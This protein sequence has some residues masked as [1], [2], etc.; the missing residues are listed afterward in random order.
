[1]A[2][3]GV[4]RAEL[5]TAEKPNKTAQCSEL[6]H[7]PNSLYTMLAAALNYFLWKQISR[8]QKRSRL[9]HIKYLA[10]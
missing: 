5:S 1:M 8:N 10:Y 7:S 4:K 3:W 6:A 2:S 9:T